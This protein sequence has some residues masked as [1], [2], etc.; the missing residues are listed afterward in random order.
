M[1]YI[2]T[3]LDEREREEFFRYMYDSTYGGINY[4]C[5]HTGITNC[6]NVLIRLKKIQEKKRILRE[7]AEREKKLKGIEQGIIII[8]SPV[9]ITFLWL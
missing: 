7:K 3:E 9:A 4:M 6:R 1:K 5:T 8:M 2:T